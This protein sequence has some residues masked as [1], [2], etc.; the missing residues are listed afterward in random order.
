M[1][2]MLPRKV[3]SPTLGRVSDSPVARA[4]RVLLTLAA[5]LGGGGHLHQLAICLGLYEAV[6]V[7]VADVV[8]HALAVQLQGV[9]VLR[10]V[11]VVDSVAFSVSPAPDMPADEADPQILWHSQASV[12]PGQPGSPV[13]ESESVSPS[14]TRNP[15]QASG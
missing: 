5:G 14:A 11:P 1:H 4:G 9:R 15:L 6:H 13:T 8:P 7:A 10:L 3:Q 12:G 2:E